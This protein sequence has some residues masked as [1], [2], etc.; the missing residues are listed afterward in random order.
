M[1]F[2]PK[3][4]V[5]NL[6]KYIT[7]LQWLPTYTKKIFVYD[8]IS[9]ITLAA[10][11]IPVSLAYATLAGLPPQYGVYGYLLGGVFY[12]LLGTSKQLAVGPTSAISLLIGST[13][14]GMAKGNVQHW[15][16]IASLTAM[17]FAAM[18]VLFYVLRMSSIINFISETILL[19]FKAGAAI[20]IGMTQLPKIF[21]IPGGG[22]NFIVCY[23]RRKLFKAQRSFSRNKCDRKT[24]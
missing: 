10:Y 6:N 8:T 24:G 22:D 19:G 16:D 11:A 17:I 3:F 20:T 18:S 21:G 4:N 23:R 13:L 12:A 14:T 15:V 7:I 1:K 9:G 5:A 2:I